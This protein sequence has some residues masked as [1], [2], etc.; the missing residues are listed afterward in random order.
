[1]ERYNQRRFDCRRGSAMSGSCG[2]QS[3][4]QNMNGAN[5][6]C[7]CQNPRQGTDSAPEAR[8]PRQGMNSSRGCQNNNVCRPNESVSSANADVAMGFVPWQQW[9]C[10][11]PLDKGFFIGTIF[12]SLDKPFIIGRCAVRP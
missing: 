10:T 2:C 7:G 3:P 4:R 8:N 12:P 11:Y 6:S 5:S 9:E 1:M